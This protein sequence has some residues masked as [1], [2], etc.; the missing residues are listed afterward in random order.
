MTRQHTYFPLTFVSSLAFK[1]VKE[2]PWNLYPQ[3]HISVMGISQ[4]HCPVSGVNFSNNISIPQVRVNITETEHGTIFE[5]SEIL[6]F[7]I[8]TFIIS[9]NGR[10]LIFKWRFTVFRLPENAF[11]IYETP[12]PPWHD[13]IISSCI[14]NNLPTRFLVQKSLSPHEKHFFEKTPSYFLFLIWDFILFLML[15]GL[16]SNKLGF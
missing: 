2:F 13:L 1:Q 8:N 9:W 4:I 14:Y 15:L 5:F 12:S 3:R 11:V 16:F 10:C 7:G 6:T